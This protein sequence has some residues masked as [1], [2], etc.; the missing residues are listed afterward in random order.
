[1]YAARLH[2]GQVLSAVDI[3]ALQEIDAVEKAKEAAMRFL[4]Y[5]PRSQAEVQQHLQKKDIPKQPFTT[6]SN[7]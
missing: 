6:L 3:A 2:L 5:R 4:S 7:A 1:M